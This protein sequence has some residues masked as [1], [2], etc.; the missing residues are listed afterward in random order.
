M[1]TEADAEDRKPAAIKDG[2]CALSMLIEMPFSVITGWAAAV[3]KTREMRFH[4][5][6]S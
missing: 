6:V 4:L 1:S 5:A 3:T 2:L